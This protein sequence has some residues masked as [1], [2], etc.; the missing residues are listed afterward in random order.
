MLAP[1]ADYRIWLRQ[2][3]LRRGDRVSGNVNE[4]RAILHALRARDRHAARAAMEVH[5]E[6]GKRRQ[7]TVMAAMQARDSAQ[8]DHGA[9]ADEAAAV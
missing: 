1:L 9:N 3:G 2:L 5:I 6:S 4:H 8:R 7:L